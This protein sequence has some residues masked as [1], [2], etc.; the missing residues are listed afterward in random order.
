MDEIKTQTPYLAP[1][2]REVQKAVGI[3]LV[4][5]SV[6]FSCSPTVPLM[7]ASTDENVAASHGHTL[8]CLCVMLNVSALFSL[9][10]LSKHTQPEQLRPDLSIPTEGTMPPKVFLVYPEQDCGAGHTY[11]LAGSF[12]HMLVLF[13]FGF[14]MITCTCN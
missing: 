12:A 9:I 6:T 3:L 5:T 13:S 4:G 2:T 8:S 7:S 10:S 14:R 1:Q 11:L